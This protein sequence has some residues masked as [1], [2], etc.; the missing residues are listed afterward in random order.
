MILKKL[1][2]SQGQLSIYVLNNLIHHFYSLFYTEC[3]GKT[4]IMT[5]W[6]KGNNLS[7][8]DENEV[9]RIIYQIDIW[10]FRWK[11]SLILLIAE[12]LQLSTIIYFPWYLYLPSKICLWI[13]QTGDFSA[14]L[15]RYLELRYVLNMIVLLW[16][17]ETN[18]M[19]WYVNTKRFDIFKVYIINN[20]YS[21]PFLIRFIR[22]DMMVI[23]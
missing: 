22:K 6:C 13:K 23:L 20:Y 2:E 16:W 8:Y 9:R 18:V 3:R 11:K 1:S 15:L 4:V 12:L 21:Y 14:Q 10:F 5:F 17:V 7:W 19:L